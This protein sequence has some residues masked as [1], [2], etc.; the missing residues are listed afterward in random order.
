VFRG[1]STEFEQ[2]VGSMQ[3]QHQNIE[4]ADGGQEIAVKVIEK[5]HCGDRMC[6][7]DE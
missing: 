2:D 6:T 4:A 7:P 1:R 3:I 5:V